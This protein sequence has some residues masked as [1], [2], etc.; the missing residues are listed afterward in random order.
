MLNY[1]DCNESLLQA[2]MTEG[3]TER[4]EVNIIAKILADLLKTSARRTFGQPVAQCRQ[5]NA[6]LV[7][8]ISALCISWRDE[9]MVPL[10]NG[11]SSI[12][13]LQQA[14]SDVVKQT[15]A[16]FSLGDTLRQAE[17][18]VDADRRERK[19]RRKEEE[20]GDATMVDSIGAGPVAPYT[21][22]RLVF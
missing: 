7:K 5:S 14:V 4:T 9:L 12:A 17:S 8:W 21:I 6:V 10:K 20:S 15:E 13:L 22:E 2:A 11:L 16:I 3:L 1:S 18:R 19:R